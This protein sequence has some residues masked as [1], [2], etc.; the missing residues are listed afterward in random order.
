[1]RPRDGRRAWIRVIGRAAATGALAETYERMKATG[2]SRPAVYDSPTG[3]VPN[4]VACHGLDPEGMRWAFGLSAVVHWGPL[5]LSWREREL[6]N[7]VT[8]RAN[9]CFY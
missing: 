8:S 3:D 9:E 6:V 1:M 2:G 5:S 7:T 4:I